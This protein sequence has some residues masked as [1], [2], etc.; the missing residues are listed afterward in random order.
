MGRAGS[1]HSANKIE[2]EKPKLIFFKE[3]FVAKD[4]IGIDYLQKKY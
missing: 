4:D 2:E 3:D 1:R